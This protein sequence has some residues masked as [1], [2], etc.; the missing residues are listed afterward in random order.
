MTKIT[1]HRSL[2][3]NIYVF[4]AHIKFILIMKVSFEETVIM[5][6]YKEVLDWENYD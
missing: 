4:S 5:I 3:M 2:F 1:R 6:C